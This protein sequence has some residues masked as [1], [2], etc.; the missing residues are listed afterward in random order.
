MASLYKESRRRRRQSGEFFSKEWSAPSVAV[1]LLSSVPFLNVVINLSV[2]MQNDHRPTII[3]WSLAVHEKN[4]V[5]PV[6]SLFLVHRLLC[7]R[8]FF[9]MPIY[10]FV[11]PKD[12]DN[13]VGHKRFPS[14]ASCLE[15]P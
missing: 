4:M 2:S 6:S 3:V 1:Q 9:I 5:C 14:K 7:H 10:D 13:P 15:Q 12:V 11:D 8:R